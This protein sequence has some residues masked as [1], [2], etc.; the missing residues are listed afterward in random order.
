MNEIKEIAK[1]IPASLYLTISDTRARYKRTML[2]PMWL[3]LG[4]LV[5]VFGLGYIWSAIFDMDKNKFIPALTVGLIVWQLIANTIT[6]SVGC[7]GR[8]GSIVKNI[9]IPAAFF[10]LQVLM[11]Q[12][13]NFA[14]NLIVMLLVLFL[15]PPKESPYYFAALVGLVLVV[16]NLLWI[17]YLISIFG[18]RYRD[19][20][21]LVAAIMPIIFFLSPVIYK[22]SQLGAIESFAWFNPFT[23]L[24]TAV[25]DPLLGTIPNFYLYAVLILSAI[26]GFGFCTIVNK[27]CNKKIAF[28]I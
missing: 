6:E 3:V 19:V 10:S 27:K 26:L 18:A 15:F 20:E 13:V 25:R 16:V 22:P 17:C 2:G 14:H 8:N 9:K 28:W 23:Y 4:T 1:Y 12:L 21:P 5:G 11:R 7:I 24:I